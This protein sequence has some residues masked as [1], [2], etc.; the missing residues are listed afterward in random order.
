MLQVVKGCLFAM[1]VFTASWGRIATSF[2]ASASAG[3]IPLNRYRSW[4]SGSGGSGGTLHCV[5]RLVM[6]SPLLSIQPA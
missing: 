3:S 5:E 6:E 4:L 2:A 1:W